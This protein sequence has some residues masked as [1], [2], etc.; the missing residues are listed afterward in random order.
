[1][2]TVRKWMCPAL[3]VVACLSILSCSDS[4]SDGAAN[5]DTN[6]PA[7]GDTNSSGDG[8]QPGGAGAPGAPGAVGGRGDDTAIGSPIKVPNITVAQGRPVDQVRGEIE[9]AIREQC[10]DEGLCVELRIEERDANFE[11]CQFVTTDPAPRSTIKRKSTV[12]IVVGTLECTDESDPG[13]GE[14]PADD[15]P[16]PAAGESQPT[17][18]STP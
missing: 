2:S 14:Q 11:S 10:G 6:S 4:D 16:S 17:I 18:D 12:V 13:G 1:M 9:A 7:N 15:D 3:A 5:G 8:G